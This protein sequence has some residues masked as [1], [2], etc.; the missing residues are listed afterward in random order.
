MTDKHPLPPRL[1][2]IR[3]RAAEHQEE[4]ESQRWWKPKQLADRWGIAVTTVYDIPASE[5]PFKTFGKG[6]KF[7]RR[8]YSPAAV[9]KFE[10]SG[11]IP[12]N[13]QKASVA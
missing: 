11:N 7:P 13:V 5:L 1:A 2:T 8:R 10:A 4:L 6:K 12:G 9:E 3:E